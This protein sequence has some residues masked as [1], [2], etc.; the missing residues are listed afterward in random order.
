[1]MVAVRTNDWCRVSTNKV[2]ENRIQ[3]MVFY[4][5]DCALLC[6]AEVR[7]FVVSLLRA[8]MTGRGIWC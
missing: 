6:G 1:M 5:L 3:S 2:S 8:A 4:V 7:R